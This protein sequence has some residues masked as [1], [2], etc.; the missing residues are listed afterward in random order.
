MSQ[1]AKEKVARWFV[2]PVPLDTPFYHDRIQQP[3]ALRDVLHK[4]RQ[5]TYTRPQEL[6]A[7]VALVRGCALDHPIPLSSPISLVSQA[8]CIS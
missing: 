5:G 8:R 6:L 7:D 3:M 2:E 4:L 1:T